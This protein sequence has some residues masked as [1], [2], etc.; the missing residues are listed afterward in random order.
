MSPKKEIV[1][2]KTA[3]VKS[4][5]RQRTPPRPKRKQ[6][7]SLMPLWILLA[8]LIAGGGTIIATIRSNNQK[9][10]ALARALNEQRNKTTELCDAISESVNKVLRIQT[11]AES[12][13][14]QT[15]ARSA[16]ILGGNADK[17]TQKE[18]AP[19]ENS[20]YSQRPQLKTDIERLESLH[21]QFTEMLNHVEAGGGTA[22]DIQGIS[23]R[24]RQEI[25]HERDLQ[26]T[27]AKVSSLNATRTRLEDVIKRTNTAYTTAEKAA[28]LIVELAETI[29]TNARLLQEEEAQNQKEEER[30]KR[31]EADIKRAKIQFDQMCYKIAS[32][33]PEQALQQIMA[34]AD[35]YK[36]PEGRERYQIL[37]EQCSDVVAMKAKI[38]AQLS[39]QPMAW[40]WKQDGAP[41]DITG[42]TEEHLLLDDRT[43]PWKN[44]SLPQ[45]GA[46]L[47]HYICGPSVKAYVRSDFCIAAAI[48]FA[49]NGKGDIA[50]TV[51]DTGTS[52]RPSIRPRVNRLTADLISPRE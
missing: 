3:P 9:A 16:L 31:L 51:L 50:T 13:Q 7:S 49:T 26:K 41:R 10:I 21:E 19:T 42:A 35:L 39:K 20:S 24:D 45:M 44:V 2:R 46:I 25:M 40:G 48:Y 27:L 18:T 14:T 22:R 4:P 15:T 47:N 36:S 28:E 1:I 29:E 12:L 32:F 43:V 33:E 17:D 52:M 6:K 5:T 30:Q 23:E 38:I 8:V 37:V 34:D 11:K